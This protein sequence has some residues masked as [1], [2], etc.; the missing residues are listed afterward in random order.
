MCRCILEPTFD[1]RDLKEGGGTKGA[2]CKI[3]WE[4]GNGE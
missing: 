1:K 4:M 2:C 3:V